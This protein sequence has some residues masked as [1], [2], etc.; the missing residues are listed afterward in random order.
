MWVQLTNSGE[1][2]DS[3]GKSL[4]MEPGMVERLSVRVPKA[5]Y[6][7]RVALDGV[8]PAVERTVRWEITGRDCA[9][10][11]YATFVSAETGSDLRLLAQDCDHT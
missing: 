6:R 1:G 2:D 11:S 7:L 9:K 10:N 5:T 8:T 4:P 3:V